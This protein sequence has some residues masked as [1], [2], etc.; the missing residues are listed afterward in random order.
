MSEQNDNKKMTK[1]KMV[2]MFAEFTKHYTE[3][4]ETAIEN[5]NGDFTKEKVE[6][7]ALVMTMSTLYE[8]RIAV[9]EWAVRKLSEA[10]EKVGLSVDNLALQT[11]NNQV[12]T[13]KVLDAIKT[14]VLDTNL[15]VKYPN[16]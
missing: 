16:K 3:Y 2:E 9:L 1:E 6:T 11:T 8:N 5:C 7:F 4:V 10:I 12:E 14:G 15:A 13:K